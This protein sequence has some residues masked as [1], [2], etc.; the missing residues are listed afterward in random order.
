MTPQLALFSSFIFTWWLFRRDRNLHPMPSLAAWIPLVWIFIIGSRSI[1]D[2]LGTGGDNSVSPQISEGSPLDATVYFVL[3]IGGGI[4]LSKRKVNW[5]ETF[6]EN[7]WVFALF[8]YWLIS[9]FWAENP[10][11]AIK[12]WVKDFGNIIM[13]M[14]ILT[15]SDHIHAMKAIFLR[16]C[17]VAL[18]LSVVFIKYYPDLGRYLDSFLWEYAYCGIT[19]EK[20]ALG[21]VS[22][23][24][25]IFLVWNLFEMKEKNQAK[26]IDKNTIS[27][28]PVSLSRIKRKITPIA[29][30]QSKIHSSVS[31]DRQQYRVTNELRSVGKMDY[32]SHA[33]LI[34]MVIWLIEKANSSTALVC[35]IMGTGIICILRSSFGKRQLKYLGLYC[36]IAVLLIV[37]LNMAPEITTSILD[38]L[39][40]DLTLTGRTDLWEQLLRT[41]INRLLGEGYQ[42]FWGETEITS[43][44]VEKLRLVF[45]PNQAHNGYLQTYLDGG[46]IAISLLFGLIITTALKLRRDVLLGEKY[47]ILCFTFLVLSV[48]YNWTE[49]M[50]NRLSLVWLI[51]LI[52]AMKYPR[53]DVFD[54]YKTVTNSNNNKSPYAASYVSR[55]GLRSV[56][57]SN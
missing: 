40:E 34:F 25:G 22:F 14:I 50:F 26:Q 11:V 30:E 44:I 6:A 32:L 10:F 8:T 27:A 52:A 37:I 9:V 31:S 4:T 55:Q 16:Y 33:L 39:G 51:L 29:S 13:V 3:I 1:T 7:R 36:F 12:R 38:M 46:L 5:S 17:Y 21:A 20:N 48:F 19:T 23:V 53:R 49:A 35:F 43:L 18:P 15:E 24:S 47:G 41:P 54:L 28:A 57:K 56:N 42:S 2:W 45:T